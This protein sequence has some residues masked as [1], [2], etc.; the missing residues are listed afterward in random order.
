MNRIA[1]RAMAILILVLAM[2]AGLVFFLFDFLINGDKW[3]AF[4]GSPHVYYDSKA[5][6][7]TLMDRDGQIL[8][9]LSGDRTYAQDEAV[10]KATLHW[11]G[12]RLGNISVPAVGYYS[13]EFVEYDPVNGVYKYG[14]TER[15][16]QLTLSASLQAVALEAMGDY[17]G[18]VA[19][20]NYQTGE[21][22]CAVTTPTYDPDN[23]PDIDGDL[24][25]AYTGVYVNRFLQSKYIPGSI[26]KIVTLAAALETVPNI[27]EQ[28]FSCTGAYAVGSGE[29]TCE[30]I[31]G[32]QSLKQAFANSCNCAFAQI[33]GQIGKDKL[34]YYVQ[35]FGVTDAITFDG[36][37]TA[38]G[39]F[40]LTD[41]GP[42]SVA[43]SGIGQYKDLVNP[44][45]FLMFV[46]SIARNGVRYQPHVV[47]QVTIGSERT[48]SAKPESVE[49]IMSRATAEVLQEYMAYNVTYKYGAENFPGLTVCA[50]SGT[51]EVGGD[52]KPNAMFTGFVSDP[53]YPLAFMVAIEDGGYG[54]RT[55]VPVISKVLQACKTAIDTQEVG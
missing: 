48:Y 46:G 27:R 10:R 36:I 18:T 3:V 42:E 38:A 25:G 13:K 53:A 11:V 40:D 20:Y 30:S 47:S 2:V 50:K 26:F 17:V 33:V 31:H 15:N 4:P 28:T 6:P 8:S 21:I 37:T 49:P 9:V 12:D 45:G 54:A 19:V 32:R 5:S 14:G 16:I 55:C 39:N 35:Q 41:A 22:L 52:R 34:N 51:G 23:V 1:T 44:C 24:T 43:W 29:V 7:V